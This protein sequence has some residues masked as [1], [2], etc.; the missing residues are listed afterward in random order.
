LQDTVTYAVPLAYDAAMR[1]CVGEYSQESFM[2]TGAVEFVDQ[3]RSKQDAAW[4]GTLRLMQVF[5]A[6]QGAEDGGADPA[7]NGMLNALPEES[8]RPF[9]DGIAE[10]L[11]GDEIKPETCG[12]IE[13][14][15][16]LLAPLPPE[17]VAGLVSF[18]VDMAGVD[19]PSLCPTLAE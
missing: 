1:Q 16:E 5:M 19:S 11:I 10:Q 8:L 2:R 18:V 9:V 3:F 14:G 13:R 7:I 15:L 4:P 17:N 12:E 6:Q